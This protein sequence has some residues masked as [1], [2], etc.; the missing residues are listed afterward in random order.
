MI[1][2]EEVEGT[3]WTDDNILLVNAWA[4]PMQCLDSD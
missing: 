4:K 2:F 1:S 3:V